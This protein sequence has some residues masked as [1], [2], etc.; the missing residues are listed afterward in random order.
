MKQ[1][2]MAQLTV[3]ATEHRTSSDRQLKAAAG[4]IFALLA[5]LAE[6]GDA[7]SQLLNH[8]TPFTEAQIKRLSATRN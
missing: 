3:L 2:L 4:V 6:G 5:A 1:K 7:T 8:L